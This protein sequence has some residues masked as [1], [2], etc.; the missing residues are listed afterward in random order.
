MFTIPQEFYTGGCF[1]A[2][3]FLGAHPAGSAP[4]AGWTFRV[5]APNALEVSVVGDF[6]DWDYMRCPMTRIHENGLWHVHLDGPD[7][8]AYYKY[9][10]PQALR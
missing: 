10:I 4:D 9:A 8:G 7:E 3:R 1:D 2:Y 5:W 6:N